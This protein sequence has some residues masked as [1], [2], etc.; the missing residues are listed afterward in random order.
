MDSWIRGFRFFFF[1]R[2]VS[3]GKWSRQ[4]YEVLHLYTRLIDPRPTGCSTCGDEKAATRTETRPSRTCTRRMSEWKPTGLSLSLS[5][6]LLLSQGWKR[7]SNQKQGLRLLPAN[8]PVEKAYLV[9]P[10]S[11]SNS[12]ASSGPTSFFVPWF[13]NLPFRSINENFE[14]LFLRLPFNE[15]TLKISPSEIERLVNWAFSVTC[16]RSLLCH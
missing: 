2:L 13:W 10:R 9:L 16:K 14:N 8:Y 7:C 15:G 3:R 1:T 4:V 12:A 11:S 5:L 6:S